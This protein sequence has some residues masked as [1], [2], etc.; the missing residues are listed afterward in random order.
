MASCTAVTWPLGSNRP[1][2]TPETMPTEAPQ[3]QTQAPTEA[4]QPQTQAPTEAPQPQTQA[5]TEAQT[6]PQ[7][8]AATEAQ[9][10]APTETVPETSAQTEPGSETDAIPEETEKEKK[11]RT[12]SDEMGQA[13]LKITLP[14]GHK[15]SADSVFK[16]TVS[17]SD[18][19]TKSLKKAESALQKAQRVIAGARFYELTLKEGSKTIG[20]PKGTV[21]EYSRDDGLSLGMDEFAQG[22]FAVLDMSGKSASPVSADMKISADGL[23]VKKVSFTAP[24]T[25][26]SFAIVGLQN[27]AADGEELSQRALR[28]D[29]RDAADYRGRGLCGQSG[30]RTEDF[31]R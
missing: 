13:S 25:I 19:D 23:S 17:K 31:R 8:Q 10:Q 22:S 7:T 14:K 1:P 20:I 28:D 9:T 12:F 27:R 4:P 29:L 11:T 30:E 21:I 3:P 6:Q 15:V 26:T 24:G 5:P 2:P 18:N 16:V